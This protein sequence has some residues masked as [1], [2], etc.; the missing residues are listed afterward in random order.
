MTTTPHYP[1]WMQEA[2]RVN[3]ER[4]A[5]MEE[6]RRIKAELL[7]A[8]QRALG[9]ALPEA[10]AFFG[11]A[12]PEQPGNR[13]EMDAV[14]F[15]LRGYDFTPVI[16]D[17][18]GNVTRYCFGLTIEPLRCAVGSPRSVLVLVRA[19]ETEYIRDAR[20]E[21]AEAVIQF[22][23]IERLLR[24]AEEMT[25]SQLAPLPDRVDAVL[26]LMRGEKEPGA[27]Q[28]EFARETTVAAFRAWALD[29]EFY[30]VVEWLDAALGEERE[31]VAS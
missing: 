8:E 2:L 26:T 18:E 22:H 4:L 7:A 25:V 12:I 23:D 28:D 20:R 16:R 15:S 6:Q 29:E 9:K 19:D 11:I 24:H 1:D 21:F 10:L 3:N 17:D 5:E 14:A 13:V 31:A 30:S 27:N